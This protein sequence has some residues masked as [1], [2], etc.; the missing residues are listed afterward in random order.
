MKMAAKRKTAYIP[1]GQRQSSTRFQA[2]LTPSLFAAIDGM[3]ERYDLSTAVVLEVLHDLA[4]VTGRLEAALF[5]AM[6]LHEDPAAYERVVGRPASA[7]A[8]ALAARSA[9]RAQY[10]TAAARAGWRID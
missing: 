10:E 5:A 8:R 7:E 6:V 9:K 1:E 3:A 4:L 2:R